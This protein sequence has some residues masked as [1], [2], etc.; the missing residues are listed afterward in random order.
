MTSSIII[1]EAERVRDIDDFIHDRWFSV[2]DVEHR[3]SAN[4]VCI[5]Y[6][7]DPGIDCRALSSV[8][9]TPRAMRILVRNATAC[10]VQD[11]Q[12]ILWY[13]FNYVLY[14]QQ[15]GVLRFVTNIPTILRVR[16]S[17]VDLQISECRASE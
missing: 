3:K 5:Y 15:S 11:T 8:R 6:S 1:S 7:D 4:E 13:D 14:D 9:G 12:R 17:S 16:V 10:E 2:Q